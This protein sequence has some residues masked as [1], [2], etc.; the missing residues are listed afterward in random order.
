MELSVQLKSWRN[1][2][3]WTQK[4]LAEKLNVSDKTISSWETGRTYPDISML[5]NLSELFNISLDE[6]MRGDSKM[7]KKIDKD[8]KLTKT[9]KLFLI[10]GVTLILCIAV[11]LNLYQGRNEWI[12][13]FNP[14]MDMKLGYATLPPT[15]TYNHGKEYKEGSKSPQVPDPYTNIWVADDPFGEGMKLTF[16]GGQSPEGKNYALVQHKGAYVRRISFVS[17]QSIPG[18]YRDIMSEKYMK[19]PEE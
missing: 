14:F 4:D 3:G 5:L 16:K 10:I 11:F 18:I 15:V 8:L 19:L 12:D 2:N 1:K 9:Y 13:R 17:W 6:F 7:I